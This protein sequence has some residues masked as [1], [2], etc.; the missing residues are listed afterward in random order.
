MAIAGNELKF[1]RADNGVELI[2][3]VM[4]NLF[5]DTVV[6]A[7]AEV[8]WLEFKNWAAQ[9]GASWSSGRVWFDY[10]FG[11]AAMQMG[12]AD[13]TV[14]ED[15]YSYSSFPTPSWSSPTDYG[16]GIVIP[17]LLPG[18]K[19]LLAIRR[20]PSAGTVAL[21]ETNRLRCL[22]SSPI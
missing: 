5:A 7:G 17:T 2:D 22:G 15:T 19:V 3:G 8:Q 4:N 9:S 18:Q 10:F 12:L 13:G 21:P 1:I 20:D 14:R 16:S 6:G 11:G